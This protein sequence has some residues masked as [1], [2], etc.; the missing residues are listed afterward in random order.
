MTG[1][2]K[3]RLAF[4]VEG[5]KWVAYYALPDTMEGAI[6][7]GSIHMGAVRESDAREAFKELMKLAVAQ[8]FAQRGATVAGWG[9]E[10]RAPEHERSGSA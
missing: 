3:G 7:L 9:G 2:P 5:D 8:L 6:W 4:R 1:E 10:T